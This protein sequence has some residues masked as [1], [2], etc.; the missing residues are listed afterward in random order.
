ML[1]ALQF[2]VVGGGSTNSK[3]RM[4][5]DV[6][7]HNIYLTS[8][9][10][11]R[12]SGWG[13]SVEVDG[14]NPSTLCPYFMHG[15]KNRYVSYALLTLSLSLHAHPF[16]F[17]FFLCYSY[18]CAFLLR[19]HWLFIHCLV[20]FHTSENTPVAPRL[21]YS[22]PELTA[23]SQAGGM[24]GDLTPQ[25]DIF[26]VGLLMAEVIAFLFLPSPQFFFLL[27]SSSLALPFYNFLSLSRF[28]K[29]HL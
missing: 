21:V 10:Q 26:S 9:G 8:D 23:A 19:V 16:F 29:Y 4:H 5:L 20:P 2:G 27:F 17:F 3:R 18:I 14:N 12:L 25:A 24:P 22:A 1:E 28:S 6:G 15:D 7:P 13:F 11:W